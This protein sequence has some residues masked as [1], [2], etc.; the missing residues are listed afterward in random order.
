MK[1]RKVAALAAV[2]APVL[3]AAGAYAQTNIGTQAP[4]RRPAGKC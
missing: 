1:L 4:D 2:A 3:L